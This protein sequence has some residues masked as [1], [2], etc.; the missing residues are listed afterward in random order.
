M[1]HIETCR[2]AC[3]GHGYLLYSGLPELYTLTNAA[4]TYEGDTD[5]LF[6]QVARYAENTIQFWALT[7]K[8][9][10][11]RNLCPLMEMT[12]NIVC[13]K[14]GNYTVHIKNTHNQIVH[15]I[16]SMQISHLKMTCSC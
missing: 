14:K 6:L 16:C 7:L 8:L 4:C 12:A 3:G 10:Q 15:I 1:R 11:Q 5:V 13:Q 2:L 9:V